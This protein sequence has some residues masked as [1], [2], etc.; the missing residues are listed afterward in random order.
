MKKGK[1]FIYIIKEDTTNYYRIGSTNDLDFRKMVLNQGN[2][3][4]LEKVCQAWFPTP[5][6]VLSVE[7][8]VQKKCKPYL[9]L[10]KNDKGNSW[11]LINDPKVIE[12]VLI[13]IDEQ[14]NN[15][16]GILK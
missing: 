12:G 7:R 2:P 5:D 8:S 10:N 3:R 9:V 14:I 16:M 15:C 1:E 13:H 6:M 11:Y 4:T